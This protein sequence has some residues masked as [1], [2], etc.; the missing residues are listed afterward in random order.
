MRESSGAITSNDGFSVVAPMSVMSPLSTCGRMASCC[1]RFHRWISSMKTTVRLPA[2]FEFAPRLFDRLA[3]LGDSR[4][5]RRDRAKDRA[6][7][8]ARATVR[9][10]S[11]RVPGGPH[12]IIEWQRARRDHLAEHLA[13]AE[14]M[15][16]ADDLV[17]AP[18]AHPVRQR[19]RRRRAW[20]RRALALKGFCRCAVGH[21]SNRSTAAERAASGRAF[22]GRLATCA[23][24]PAGRVCSSLEG[25]AGQGPA[26]FYDRWNRYRR[27]DH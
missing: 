17:E 10:W 2:G 5:H 1:A 4:R 18:R 21:H 26:P 13:G 20:P 3:Q 12:R 27:I 15:L 8:A 22:P 9:S 19:L 24:L 6:G 16:L 25:R 7:A 14:Q 11:C 23:C